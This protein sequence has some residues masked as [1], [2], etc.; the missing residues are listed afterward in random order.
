MKENHLDRIISNNGDTE[1]RIS[2]L[3]GTVVRFVRKGQDVF[4]PQQ[5]I[6]GKIR[7]GM[8]LCAPW[9]GRSDRGG[10]NHGYLRDTRSFRDGLQSKTESIFLFDL[11]SNKGYPWPLLTEVSHMAYDCPAD[12]GHG[13]FS[14]FRSTLKIIRSEND[15]IVDRAPIL[16]GFHPYFA[17]DASKVVV[18]IGNEQKEFGGFGEESRM[19]PFKANGGNP[20]TICLPGRTIEMELVGPFFSFDS[21]LVFWSDSPS[22]YFCVE[23]ILQ[24]P[25]QFE[26]EKGCYLAPGE[27]LEI[28]M[29]LR[30][31]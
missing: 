4:F 16:P 8:P 13:P 19:I 6:G 1:A 9:F 20:V 30:V 24:N 26:T 10:K 27:S 28:S 22:D 12:A 21:H 3:G 5:E 25:A 11:V 18:K 17:G 14:F 2:S 7:G 31:F 29:I 23:P 15:K